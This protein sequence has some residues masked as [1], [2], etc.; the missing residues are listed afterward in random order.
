MGTFHNVVIDP[1]VTNGMKVTRVYPDAITTK[2]SGAEER[3]TKAAR[4]KKELHTPYKYLVRADYEALRDFYELRLGRTCSFLAWDPSDLYAAD[5]SLGTGDGSTTVFQIQRVKTD[6][7]HNVS[8]PL[9]HPVPAYPSATPIPPQHVGASGTGATSV[10]NTVKVDGVLKTEGTDY[11]VSAT[12]GVITF[13]SAPAAGKA[14]TWSGWFYITVRFKE[15]LD[16]DYDSIYADAE[17]VLT[18]VLFE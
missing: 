8:W 2:G 14:V 13:G 6:G 16:M 4:S 3:I 10:S 11:S 9:L 15:F 17:L 18:E 12:T 7:V 5:Q 1:M